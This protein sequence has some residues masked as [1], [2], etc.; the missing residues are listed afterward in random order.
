MKLRGLAVTLC[1][2]TIALPVYSPGMTSNAAPAVR[3]S[4]I[5]ILTDDLDLKSISVMPKLKSLMI[6]RG[7]SFA[8]YFVTYPLCCPSRAS[9]LRGQYP[10]NT[11]VLGNRPPLGGFQKFVETGA[12]RSTVAT[13]LHAAGYRTGY[14]GKYLNGYPEGN[15]Q[16]HIPP[17]WDI[18]NSP[19]G[20]RPYSNFNYRMNENGRLVSY[21]DRPEDYMTDVLARKAGEFIRQSA[22]ANRS[23]FIHLSTYTPHGPATPAPRHA[24]SFAGVTA[25]RPPSFNETEVSDKPE[26]LRARVPLTDRQIGR[27]DDLYRRRLQTLLSVDDLIGTLVDTLRATGRL[28]QTYIFFTSDNGFHLGEHRLPQGKNTAFEEDIRVPLIVIGPGVA[29]ARTIEHLAMNIDL[30]PTWTAIAGATMPA[31]VD[32]RSLLSLL[33]AAPP[34]VDTWRQM[35][36]IEH[37]SPTRAGRRARAAA[38]P[39][40]HAL[41]VKDFSY[42]EY[43]TGERELYDLRS[44]QYQLQNVYQT[45]DRGLVATFSA[46][47]AAL[48]RCTGASC[49]TVEDTAFPPIR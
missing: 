25:P 39:D 32:G 9:I 5:F 37:Y 28:Q 7:V 18:W 43:A 38:I 13:W 41:R 31:F 44:D 17:G 6:D 10:H 19:A 1:A 36:L 23:F 27:I 21:G 15:A 2:V 14:F 22:Q 11:Q 16:T 49:R 34:R 4:I 33:S 8:N 26:W 46:R 40:Y 24:D 20:G 47:L 30:A 35:V 3:P 45:A 48:K 29:E 42:V 12:E